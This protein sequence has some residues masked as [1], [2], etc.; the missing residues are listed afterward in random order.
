MLHA[1][2]HF[3]GLVATRNA[4]ITIRWQKVQIFFLIESVLL[5]AV[6]GADVPSAVRIAGCVFGLALTVTWA[7]MQWEAQNAIDYWTAQIALTERRG[8]GTGA[9]SF[10]FSRPREGFRLKLI[11][12]HYLILALI[13]MFAAG[14]TVLI[15]IFLLS[16]A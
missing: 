9:G 5:G 7:L 14:W 16:P 2:T 4:E 1:D 6:V 3:S 11:S 12:T 10:T 8:Q 15:A 13:G